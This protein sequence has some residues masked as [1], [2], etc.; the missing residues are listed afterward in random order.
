MKQTCDKVREFHKRHGFPVDRPL[1]PVQANM[2]THVEELAAA[3]D[4]EARRLREAIDSGCRD[5][6]IMRLQ[7]ITEELSEL[8]D[9]LASNDRIAVADAL[10]DLAYVVAGSA[11]AW[12]LPLGEI[13]DE[14]HRSNMS[15][16]AH[17]G[18][19]PHKGRGYKAPDIEAILWR[20]KRS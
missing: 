8:A 2:A 9:A 10:G 1:E 7:L 20:Y 17:T 15:K 11:V 19:K 12:G 13:V 3:L 18:H 14:I 5:V 16:D 4:G 6:G